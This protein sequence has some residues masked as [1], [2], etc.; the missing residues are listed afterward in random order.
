MNGLKRFSPLGTALGLLFMAL[1]IIMVIVQKKV[2]LPSFISLTLSLTFFLLT[3]LPRGKDLTPKL[4]NRQY[5]LGGNSIIILICVIGSFLLVNS[6]FD[7]DFFFWDITT[8]HINTLSPRSKAIIAQITHPIAI[9][10][11]FSNSTDIAKLHRILENYARESQDRISYEILNPETNPI[12]AQEAGIL[13]DGVILLSMDDQREMVNGVDEAQIASAIYSLLFPIEKHVAFSTGHSEGDIGGFSDNPFFNAA[14]L[15]QNKNYRVSQINLRLQD[16]IPSELNTIIVAGPRNSFTNDEV[17]KLKFFI[18]EKKGLLLLLEPEYLTKNNIFNDPLFD[19]CTK[20]FGIEF[21]PDII[22]D[23]NSLIPWGVTARPPNLTKHPVLSNLSNALILGYTSR[24]INSGC[25]DPEIHCEKILLTNND[26]WGETSFQQL[27]QG[28][29]TEDDQ[30][31]PGPLPFAIA[32]ELKS[33][34]RVMIIGDSSFANDNYIQ[35][36]SNSDFF[37]NVI[38]WLS[39][40]EDVIPQPQKTLSFRV[41]KNLTKEQLDLIFLSSVVLPPLIIIIAGITTW[42]KRRKSE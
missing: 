41:L 32:L 5:R 14:T 10:A 18:N 40:Q 26:A 12:A 7:K 24:S 33:G 42:L 37:L 27:N 15:L 6:F 28:Q 20:V 3:I 8:D 34:S 1:T 35:N 11:F 23:P 17:S 29:S 25:N 39:Y 16:V 2:Y 30:D 21:N 22:I 31:L 4:D 36:F 9:K 19:F 13:H 38:D